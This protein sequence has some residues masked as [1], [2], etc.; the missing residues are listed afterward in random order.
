MVISASPPPSRPTSKLYVVPV[1]CKYCGA[2]DQVVRYGTY[3]GTQQYCCKKCF[4]KF[5]DNGALSGMH[6]PVIQVISALNMFYEGY[7]LS[8][9][10]RHL[11]QTYQSY[12]SDSSIYSWIVTFTKKAIQAS[13]GYAVPNGNIWLANESS[14][15]VS[16]QHLWLFDAM[17]EKSRFL[18][19]SYISRTKT[20]DDV[21][22]FMLQATRH[23][24]NSPEAIITEKRREYEEGIERVFGADTQPLTP[25]EF[26]A[27]PGLNLLDKIHCALKVRSQVMQH[28]QN[29]EAAKM[30]LNGWLIHYNFFRPQEN[31]RGET[32]AQ[33]AKVSFPYR[34]WADVVTMRK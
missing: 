18:L 34:S 21:E 8:G 17:D 4:R 7:H 10:R 1:R 30:I 20:S 22:K 2:T 24:G 15:K 33:I 14:I 13:S 3:H 5:V 16:G 9:I 29:K 31:L 25:Q 27:Q 19:T 32:P 28:M 23:S 11:I 26:T 6:T 12:P